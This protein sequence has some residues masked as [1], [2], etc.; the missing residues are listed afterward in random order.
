MYTVDA[1]KLA[2]EWLVYGKAVGST[3]DNILIPSQSLN[4]RTTQANL[5][6]YSIYRKEL[7]DA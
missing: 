3:D 5:H 7:Q 1:D 6:I 2:S 4:P